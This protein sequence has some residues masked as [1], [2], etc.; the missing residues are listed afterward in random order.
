M[1]KKE[2]GGAFGTYREWRGVYKVLIRRPEGKRQLGRPRCKW[3]NIKIRLQEVKWG[4]M[5][6]ID[7]AQGR[8]GWW[9]LVNAVM[10]IRVP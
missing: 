1:K 7:L 4:A 2:M 9:G 6:W 8:G 5:E 10:N 3:E